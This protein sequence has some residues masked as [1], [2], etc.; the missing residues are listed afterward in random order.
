MRYY[1]LLLALPIAACH[2]DQPAANQLPPVATAPALP[3]PPAF[4]PPAGPL[5][6]GDTERP[7]D[8]DTLHVPGGGILYLK[9]TTAAAFRQVPDELRTNVDSALTATGRVRR[10]G[11]DLL[12]QPDSGPLVKFTA[13]PA[14]EIYNR[15]RYLGALAGAHLWVVQ[16]DAEGQTVLTLI[17][18][19]TGRRTVVMGRPAVSP[20]GQYLFS[21]HSGQGNDGSDE[22]ATGMEL[23]R[24]AADGPHLLWTR[25]TQHWGTNEARWSGPHT[26]LLRQDYQGA[27]Q[28][29]EAPADTYVEVTLPALR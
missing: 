15:P 2:P 9:P 1:F 29:D 6:S 20:D 18:Q 22:S 25:D 11:D 10:V 26:V 5:R 4:T 21:G 28:E 8:H 13:S 23:Y 24:L 16:T 7:T 19:R 14:N 3:A 17:D 27:S 12:L